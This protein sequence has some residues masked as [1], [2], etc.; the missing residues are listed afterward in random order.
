[1]A[2]A[3]VVR[4]SK[5]VEEV[6]NAVQDVP[7]VKGEPEIVMLKDPGIIGFVMTN[8]ALGDLKVGELTRV[9]SKIGR[10]AGGPGGLIVHDGHIIVGFMPPMTKPEI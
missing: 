2:R 6:R 3:D 9:A 5:L 8:E 7:L 1:M 10:A 4:L